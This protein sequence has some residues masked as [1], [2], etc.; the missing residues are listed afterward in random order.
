MY[1]PIFKIFPGTPNHQRKRRATETR[2]HSVA[3]C[4]C[5]AAWR[6]I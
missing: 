4:C 3:D 1:C 5:G 2:A 6:L